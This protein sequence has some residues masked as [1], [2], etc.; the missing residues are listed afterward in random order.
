M[1]A[2]EIKVV[3]IIRADDGRC[4]K[5]GRFICRVI[6]EESDEERELREEQEVDDFTKDFLL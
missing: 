3:P 1:K 2:P 5:C 4:V 6:H